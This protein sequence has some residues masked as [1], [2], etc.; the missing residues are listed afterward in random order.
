MV[1]YHQVL[2]LLTMAQLLVVVE[3]VVVLQVMTVTASQE[4]VQQAVVLQQGQVYK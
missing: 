2:N 4:G 1:R 3:T